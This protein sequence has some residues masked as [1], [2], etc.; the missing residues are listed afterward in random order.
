MT[1]ILVIES[2]RRTCTDLLGVLPVAAE[3]VGAE[4]IVDAEECID[5]EGPFDVYVVQG[6]MQDGKSSGDIRVTLSFLRHLSA[7]QPSAKVFVLSGM[8]DH[9]PT[10]EEYKKA[11]AGCRVLNKNSVLNGTTTLQI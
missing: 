2:D 4:N 3:G 7:T 9:G 8:F 5:E 11:F 1:R 10:V 6:A